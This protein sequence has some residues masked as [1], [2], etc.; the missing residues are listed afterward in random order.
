MKKSFVLCERGLLSWLAWHV[1]PQLLITSSPSPARS[2]SDTMKNG[3][4]LTR[5]RLSELWGTGVDALRAAGA[6]PG[7][8]PSAFYERRG[9]AG[10]GPKKRRRRAWPKE[11]EAQGVA[12]RRGGAERG[13][14]KRRRRAWPPTLINHSVEM[15]DGREPVSTAILR[16][17]PFARRSTR[18]RFRSSR[19]ALFPGRDVTTPHTV[20]SLRST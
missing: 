19:S 1:K 4:V 16:F 18:K 15:A 17:T 11:E 14:K 12:Q 2:S 7:I 9:G 13:P 6:G 3:A 8:C 10:R 20:R 5:S